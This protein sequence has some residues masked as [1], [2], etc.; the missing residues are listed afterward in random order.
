MIKV[1]SP[2]IVQATDYNEETIIYE[3]VEHACIIDAV[4]NAKI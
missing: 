3:L 2:Y 1:K 4:S